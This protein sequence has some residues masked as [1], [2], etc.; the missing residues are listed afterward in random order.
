MGVEELYCQEKKANSLPSGPRNNDH[1]Y[2]KIIKDFSLVFS[3]ILIAILIA[4][5][6][7]TR[8]R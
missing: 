8:V 3:L 4:S 5:P 2:V 7:C 6:V 1:M